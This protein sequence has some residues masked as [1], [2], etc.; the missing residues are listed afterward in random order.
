MEPRDRHR[1]RYSPLAGPAV[2][3]FLPARAEH[4][5]PSDRSDYSTSKKF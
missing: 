5:G 2:S 3:A 4:S 1:N